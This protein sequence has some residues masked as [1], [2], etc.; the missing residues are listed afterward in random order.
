MQD[1]ADY[2]TVVSVGGT[3]LTLPAPAKATQRRCGPS[4]GGGCSVVTK[5]SWQH[6]P[7]CSKRTGNDVAA[8]AASVAEYDSYGY[9]G[10]ITIGGTSVSSPLLAGVIGLAGNASED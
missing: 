7:T 6:D 9:A 8:V 4:S 10:W 1:P 5:P 3:V 2:S